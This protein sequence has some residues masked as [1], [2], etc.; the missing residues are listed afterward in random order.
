MYKQFNWA[1]LIFLVLSI[2]GQGCSDDSSTLDP[3]G[4]GGGT[5]DDGWS[6]QVVENG[7]FANGEINVSVDANS[8]LH[9]SA[10]NFDDGLQYF[11]NKSGS[12]VTTIIAGD[13]A[14]SEGVLN[15]ITVDNSVNVH[16]VYS[17][18]G[19]IAYTTNESGAWIHEDMWLGGAG[20]CTI[21]SDGGG[22]LH[23]AFDDNTNHDIRYAYKPSGGAWGTPVALADQWVGSNCD[24]D[25]DSS[26]NP[27]VIFNFSGHHNLRYAFFN[28]SWNVS[29]IEGSDSYPY[30]PDTGW[31]P[32]I[33][34]NK[35]T[36]AANIAFWNRSDS[37]V[38]FSNCATNSAYTLK[39][40]VGK[41]AKPCIALDNEGYAHVFFEENGTYILYYATNKSGSWIVTP[42]TAE[43]GSNEL[44]MTIDA[45]NMIH[46]IF[47]SKTNLYLY[48]TRLQL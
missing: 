7:N 40:T 36:N 27:H 41:W 48:H 35:T 39:S 26:G 30:E 2:A 22:N 29:T 10:F 6:T 25:V 15:D 9:V 28:G 17:H 32:A 12:W 11:T 47:S 44:A 31:T 23:S 46:V 38:Q 14:N 8:K 13:I 45:G 24:I 3:A 33:A 19:G 18:S 1:L 21:V 34:V 16:I 20:S 42:L 37:L 43:I 4:S 5:N